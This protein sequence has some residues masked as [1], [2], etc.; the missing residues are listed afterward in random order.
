VKVTNEKTENR[1]AYL[2]IE[3]EPAEIETATEATYRKLVKKV[4]VPGF[5]RGKAPR[6]VFERHFGKHELFHEMLD[7][8][9]PHIYEKA[10]EEQKLE[11]VSQPELEVIEEEPLVLSAVIPLKPVITLGDYHSIDLQP[12]KLEVTEEMINQVIERLQHQNATWEPVDR[13]VT[14]NDLTTMDIKSL[15]NGEP[16]INREGINF[17]VLKDSKT[18]AP[19][20]S[21]Q[22]IGMSKGG[23]K[24]FTLQIP[25]DAN[26][27]ETAGKEATF[28]IKIT[29]IKEEKMTEVTDAF[30]TEV[31]PECKTVAELREKIKEDLK[32]RAEEQVK[33]DFEAKVVEAATALSKVEYP[34][35][36]VES[37]I[38]RLLERE[39][40][41]L[42]QTGQNAEQYLKSV[43]RTIE[44][45]REE[46][47]PA[48]AIRVAQF[49][50]LGSISEAEK[51][52]ASPAE[53]DAEVEVMLNNA[54]QDKE[55]MS[56]V[57]AMP[58][59]RESVADTLITRKVIQHLSDIAQ[60][61]KEKKEE[62]K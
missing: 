38:D 6:S 2:K 58:R 36:L 51:L 5:R 1:Q 27:K 37:E 20:F 46:L 10:I 25:A 29:E 19:G 24:S 26:D 3:V 21:E 18:P 42:E 47:R 35:V 39:F 33:E 8:L 44:Q 52:E 43:N 60:K 40:R 32:K 23:E 28:H 55:I 45:E 56:K 11:P 12:E 9:V 54:G 59:G 17:P 49:L 7:E 61:P 13:E 31:N 50:V 57:L 41:F 15:L 22:L 14:F 48:A 16:F 34:P 62:T 53:I 4:N 30:A